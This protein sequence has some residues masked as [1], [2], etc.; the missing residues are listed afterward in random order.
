MRTPALAAGVAHPQARAELWIHDMDGRPIRPA[1]LAQAELLVAEGAAY[2]VV[3]AAGWK[4]VRLKGILPSLRANSL[5]TVKGSDT[6]PGSSV[7][8]YEHNYSACR[9]W[10]H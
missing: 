9:T 1:T 6:A 5:R 10:K 4:Q 8:T 2:P 3:T 7:S